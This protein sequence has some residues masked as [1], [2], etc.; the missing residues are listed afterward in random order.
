MA[1]G[2]LFAASA[3]FAWARVVEAGLASALAGAGV[4]SSRAVPAV[5]GAGAGAFNAANALQLS[6]ATFPRLRITSQA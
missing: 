1:A 2:G 3:F 4:A 5:E 6:R